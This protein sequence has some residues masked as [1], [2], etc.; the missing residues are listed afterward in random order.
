MPVGPGKTALQANSTGVAEDGMGVVPA[1]QEPNL[2]RALNSP[3]FWSK[4]VKIA[5][6]AL[7]TFI[8]MC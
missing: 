4:K 7:A 3:S 5:I 1:G 2:M 6:L 8:A